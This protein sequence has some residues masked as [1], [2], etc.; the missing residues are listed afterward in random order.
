MPTNLPPDYYEV[1]KR[2]KAAQTQP[3]KIELLE[4]MISA[5]PKHKGTDHLRADLRRRLSKMKEQAASQKK[6]GGP[7]SPF[8]IDKEGAGQVVVIGPANTGKSTLVAGLTNADPQVSPSPFTTWGPTPGMMLVEDVQV[9][10]IDTPPTDRDFVE[11]EMYQL[12][13]RADML[14]LMVDLEGD[15][16]AQLEETVA[17]LVENRVVPAHLAEEHP[18][19]GSKVVPVLALCNKNDDE[20]SDENYRIF[21]Q[22]M[23]GEWPCIPVSAA[24]GRNVDKMQQAV[25]ETLGIVRIYSKA[26]NQEPDLGAPFVMK[27]GGTVDDFARKLHKDFYEKLKSARVWGSSDFDGQMVGRDYVLQDGDVVEL[28]I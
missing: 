26:P 13:R 23:E 3:E 20:E 9:Q 8:N 15:P 10:L 1:E 4:E 14:L 25:F 21:C 12:M 5:I 28:K 11:P 6:A 16:V 27:Q 17:R 2:Y 19:R 7:T 22:L 24:T 18:E